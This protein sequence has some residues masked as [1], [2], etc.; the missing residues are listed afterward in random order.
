[1]AGGLPV[2]ELLLVA[3]LEFADDA[4]LQGGGG[5][6]FVRV[7][8]APLGGEFAFEGVLKQ[9]LAINLELGLGGFQAFGPLIQLGKQFLNFGD[10]AVLFVQ[11]WKK[12]FS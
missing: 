10:D 9:R 4:L 3:G 1:M 5:F 7:I 6:E 12:N 2:G 8:G 11:R